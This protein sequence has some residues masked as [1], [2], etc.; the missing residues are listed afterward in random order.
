[1][2]LS[3]TASEIRKICKELKFKYN[4]L[5][6]SSYFHISMTFGVMINKSMKLLL[7]KILFAFNWS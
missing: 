5:I 2:Q 6:N 4:L 1:M 3:K 7:T